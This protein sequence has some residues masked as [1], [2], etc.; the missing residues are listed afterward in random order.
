MFDDGDN[1]IGLL[2]LGVCAVVAGVL[3]WEIVTG[4]ELRYTGPD[5]LVW[6]LAIV[7]VGGSLYGLS[8]GGGLGR[9]G[10]GRRWPDPRTGQRSW[11]RRLFGGRDDDGRL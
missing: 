2:L 1:L 4:G 7:F 10:G 3:V 8:R 9:M 6:I 5:W 11:W